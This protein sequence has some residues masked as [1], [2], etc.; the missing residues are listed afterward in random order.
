EDGNDHDELGERE[1]GREQHAEGRGEEDLGHVRRGVD[2]PGRER[3]AQQEAARP[4]RRQGGKLVAGGQERERARGQGEH[5]HRA[6]DDGRAVA[7]AQVGQ[8]SGEREVGQRRR[9]RDQYGGRSAYH[10]PSAL[11][12][13]QK[14]RLEASSSSASSMSGTYS[15]SIDGVSRWTAPGWAAISPASGTSWSLSTASADLPI[16][17]TFLS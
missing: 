10:S 2:V 11:N 8:R 9:V 4:E 17:T 5:R 12:A 3:A 15:A 7:A 14:A 16:D 1:P 6:R 13:R